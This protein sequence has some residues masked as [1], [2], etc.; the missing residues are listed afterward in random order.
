MSGFTDIHHHLIYGL[1]DGPRQMQE[2]EA[3]LQAAAKDETEAIIA[4]PHVTPGIEPFESQQYMERLEE[5]RQYCARRNLPL[6][7]YTGAEILYTPMSAKLLRERRIPTLAGTDYVLVEFM[8]NVRYEDLQEAVLKLLRNGFLPV[9]AHVER[10]GCLT[11]YVRRTARMKQTYE[12]SFQVNCSTVIGGK[13]FW[14][15]R[16]VDYLLKE[17]LVDYVASDAHNTN[18]RPTRMKQ[19]YRALRERVG[20]EYAASLMGRIPNA[21][22]SAIE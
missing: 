12:V 10:Y 20:Q 11:H 3:M 2:T 1:D 9:L 4:T 16:C 19:A 8:P 6:K 17:H 5:A 21:L 18:V 14:V 7:L 13:G 15:N 22:T